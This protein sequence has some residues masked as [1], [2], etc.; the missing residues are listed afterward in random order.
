[1]NPDHQPYLRAVNRAID[2][3]MSDLGSPLP[4]DAVA[5]H[6]G[7]SPY[8]FHRIFAAVTGETPGEYTARVR[9]EQAMIRMSYDR[10]ASLTD[11]AMQCGFGDVS[12]FSRA[13][14]Q[15]HGVAPSRFDLDGFTA[16]QRQRWSSHGPVERL[17]P[18]DDEDRFPVMIK[19]LPA[20]TVAYLRVTRPYEG[21]RVVDAA[22][23]LE[24]WADARG[25][26][27]GQWLGY[28]W[29]IPEVVPADKC[30]YDVGVVIPGE[31]EPGGPVQCRLLPEM[32]VAEVA[33]AGP[34]EQEIA[35]LTWL[36]RSWLPNSGHV[37][38]HLPGFE[39]WAGRPFAHGID[40]FELA[41][42]VPI[43]VGRQRKI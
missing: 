27:D 6:A 16:E 32:T 14:K 18:T 20:R 19:T 25:L 26:A 28:T 17:P 12:N 30:R 13:F 15:R 40:H 21:T 10:S 33:V 41:V 37:P 35:A 43:E 29:D 38:A 5:A 34:I 9:M 7:F 2:K 11:I 42:Q 31:A 23:R 24:R 39:A 3:I 22:A 8:H 1:M 36:Y 4:L